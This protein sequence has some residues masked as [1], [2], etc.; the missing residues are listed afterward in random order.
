MPNFELILW[1]GECFHYVFPAV[2]CTVVCSVMA[3]LVSNKDWSWDSVSFSLKA[4]TKGIHYDLTV[5]CG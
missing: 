2:E 4:Q 5:K 1:L 3:S